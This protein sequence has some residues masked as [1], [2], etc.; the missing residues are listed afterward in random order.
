MDDLGTLMREAVDHVDPM[1]RQ[2]ELW[3]GVNL[4]TRR[5]SRNRLVGGLVAAAVLVTGGAVAAHQSSGSEPQ[6]AGPPHAIDRGSSRAVYGIYYAGQTPT[7]TRLYR[8]FRAGQEKEKTLADALDLVEATPT[9]PDYVT[10][11]SD[12]QLLGATVTNGVIV[13]DVDPALTRPGLGGP[14]AELAIQQLVYT[15]QGVVGD[16]LPVQFVHDG[17]PVP[18]VFGVRTR[19]PVTDLPELDVLSL[20]SI[21]DPS[22]RRVVDG[23]FSAQGK[24][25]SFEGNVP[26]QL[27]DANG[28]VV[29]SGHA[30]SYGYEGHLYPWATGHIDV[31]G[32]APGDYTFK[33]M[34]DDPSGGEGPGPYV[35][36][37]TIIIK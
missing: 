16:R 7:G 35:D 20:V 14:D 36:T 37:R 33:V 5:R 23:Y 30:Q 10:Y 27:L 21:S 3:D 26:W 22:E 13:V 34:T 29:R 19:K 15:V 12:G 9:D 1:P 25:S 17:S 8:E 31:T 6:P 2:R 32:L 28:S 24:A 18:E 11:W 4:A